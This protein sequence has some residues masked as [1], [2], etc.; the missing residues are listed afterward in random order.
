MNRFLLASLIMLLAYPYAVSAKNDDKIR[1]AITVDDLPWHSDLPPGV[2]RQQV[3]KSIIKSLKDAD[4]PKV[5]GFIN[6]QYLD[7]DPLLSEVYTDWRAA[8][9]PLG[10]H[11]WS[12]ANLNDLS[13]DAYV[14]EI[15]KNETALVKYSKGMDWHWF[16]FPYLVEGKEADKRNA[17]RAELAK[18]GYHIAAVTMSFADYAWNPPYARCMAKQD[19]D[20]I[21]LLERNYLIVAADA[22]EQSHVMS[23]ALYGRDI[24]YVLLMHIGAFDAHMFP[25]L[26]AMYKA[27]KVKLITLDEAE[28]DPVYASD[29]N[30]S[31]PAEPS[32][33]D[34]R[35]WARKMA[36]PGSDPGLTSML[37][38]ICK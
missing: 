36:V 21:K 18:R 2:T 13:V 31:L 26:L 14:E 20:A 33:L 19:V 32:G 11:T 9:F 37:N 29:F 23:R 35:M 24:P 12:H 6:A 8:G 3:A 10:N 7:T 28:K 22:I 27:K 25:K 4:A 5:Y 16:R 1:I 34:A 15:T 30:P 17:V 38:T